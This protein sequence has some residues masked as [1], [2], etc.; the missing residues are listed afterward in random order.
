MP[1][2]NDHELRGFWFVLCHVISEVYMNSATNVWTVL[3]DGNVV[4]SVS[5]FT[6][7]GLFPCEETIN[8]HLKKMFLKKEAKRPQLSQPSPVDDT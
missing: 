5:E 6:C 3:A 8:I 7:T 4:L 2:V 1:F